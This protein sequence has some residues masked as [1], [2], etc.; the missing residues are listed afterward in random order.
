MGQPNPLDYAIQLERDGQA[1]YAKAAA[2]TKSPLGRKM[3]ESLAADEG[4]HE[5]VLRGVARKMAVS[6]EGDMP[7]RRLVTLFATLGPDLKAQ[8]GADPSDSAV[9]EKA[10]EMEKASVDLYRK[11]AAAA[12]G[13]GGRALYER[14][15]LE[16]EQHVD[17]LSNTLTYLDSTAS[18]FLWDEQALLDGG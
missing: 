4:R 9:I 7:R 16:E 5:A 3:Y 10:I 13:E 15:T 2:E 6:L 14:L 8:L 11:Q 1:F 17:I 18:W 12:Q